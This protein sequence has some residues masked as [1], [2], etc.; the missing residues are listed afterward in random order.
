MAKEWDRA[1]LAMTAAALNASEVIIAFGKVAKMI[2]VTPIRSMDHGLISIKESD[3]FDPCQIV[4]GPQ[5]R[6]KKGKIKRW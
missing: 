5:K 4:H 6:G 2:S 1:H 3:V